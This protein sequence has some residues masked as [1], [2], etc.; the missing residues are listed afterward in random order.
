MKLVALALVMVA[1]PARGTPPANEP[2]FHLT[3]G[4]S[5]VFEVGAPDKPVFKLHSD[6][7]IEVLLTFRH[8]PPEWLAGGVFKVDGTIMVNGKQIGALADSYTKPFR[9]GTH[10]SIAGNT[11][12]IDIPGLPL[13]TVRLR[14]DKTIV[15]VGRPPQDPQHWRIEA[16]DPA[17]VRTTFL[18]FGTN[19]KVAID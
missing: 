3:F 19:L 15:L 9:D 17:V 6:G 16:S 4:E 2:P 10:M 8:K 5:T 7:A 12:S 1:G 13:A 14:D 11:I 18:V